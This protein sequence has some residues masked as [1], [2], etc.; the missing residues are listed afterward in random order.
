MPQLVMI[1][2]RHCPKS[3][4]VGSPGI[5]WMANM[6]IE[7]RLRPRWP[8]VVFVFLMG[9]YYMGKNRIYRLFESIS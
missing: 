3:A 9:L 6:M 4:P 8:H 5:L 2:T 7:E 1:H